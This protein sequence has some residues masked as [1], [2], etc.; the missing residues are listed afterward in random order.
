MPENRLHVAR[1]S[2]FAVHLQGGAD[3]PAQRYTLRLSLRQLPRQRVPD[4]EF[5]ALERHYV[6]L[7]EEHLARD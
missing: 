1:Q 4:P 3:A 5:L 6:R 7:Y 2:A